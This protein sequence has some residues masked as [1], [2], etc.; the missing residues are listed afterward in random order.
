MR[1]VPFLVLVATLGWSAATNQGRCAGVPAV[2]PGVV[3][4]HCSPKTR[5][6]IGSPSL[7]VLPTGEYIAAHDFCG[8]GATPDSTALFASQDHGQTWTP[9]GE[10]RGQY[11][12]TLF[13]HHKALYLMGTSRAYGF[14]VIRRS[15]D[16]GHTW[17]IPVDAASC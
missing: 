5:R 11:W 15:S 3:I 12:S 13:V 9:R 8:R 14:A 7:M 1:G 10:V 4:D 6:F 2:V 17:T 16:G